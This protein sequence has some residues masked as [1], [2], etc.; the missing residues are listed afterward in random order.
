MKILT[1]FLIAVLVSF[2]AVSSASASFVLGFE[3]EDGNLSNNEELLYN[4]YNNLADVISGNRSGGA[5]SPV[6]LSADY[7]ISGIAANNNG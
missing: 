1:A 7:S 5:F 2:V 3:S 4:T 6:D